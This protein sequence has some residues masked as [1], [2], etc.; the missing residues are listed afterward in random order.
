MRR[1]IRI[2][3]AGALLVCT[4]HWVGSGQASPSLAGPTGV[5]MIPSALTLRQWEVD[6][7]YDAF[8][9]SGPAD[10]TTFSSARLG[11]GLTDT[12]DSGFELGVMDPQAR[13]VGL[14][15]PYVFGKYRLSGYLPGG[16]LAVGGTFSTDKRHYSSLFLVGS[17]S[18]A[19]NLVLHYGVGGNV[20]GDPL[21]YAWYGGRQD[22]GRADPLFA[23]FGAEIDWKRFK[24]NV[25]YNGSFTSY[26]VNFFPDSFFS[27]QVYK[28]G[29][30]EYERLLGIQNKIGV[31][32]TARF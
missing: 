15:D 10:T 14:T 6:L 18:I 19:S 29:N 4:A 13:S 7:A 11:I 27:L 5:L 20:F 24:I 21:G 3:V 12:A 1:T 2:W 32:A 23:L 30:G 8:R 26:G 16:A 25:D 28:I 22:S 17:S 9:V 31:G